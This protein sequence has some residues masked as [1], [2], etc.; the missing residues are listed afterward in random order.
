MTTVQERSTGRQRGWLYLISGIVIGVLIVLA[1]LLGHSRATG[2]AAE[3]KAD[4]LITKLH[5]A[6]AARVPSQD[7]LVRLLGEDGGQVCADPNSALSR[8]TQ[9]AGI[10]NGAGGP[11]TRPVI[12]DAA[13]VR[14]TGLVI[15]VYCPEELAAYQQYVDGLTFENVAGGE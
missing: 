15:E 14:G 3:T 8:A 9:Q 5:E 10:A 7:Q 1:V 11:G 4:Q 6:G 2:L 13:V 12:S